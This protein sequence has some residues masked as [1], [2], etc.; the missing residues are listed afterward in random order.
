MAAALRGIVS[1]SL[2]GKR[3]RPGEKGKKQRMMARKQL[4]KIDNNGIR[5][6]VREERYAITATQN[7]LSAF[8]CWLAE[9]HNATQE[10]ILQALAEIDAIMGREDN[11]QRLEQAVGIR[12]DARR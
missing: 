2:C 6:Y 7:F 12:L 5:K 11:V 10:D 3:Q 4:L 9:Y 1:I 8:G